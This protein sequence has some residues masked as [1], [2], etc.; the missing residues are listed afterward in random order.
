MLQRD[1]LL[2]FR[3]DAPSAKMYEVLEA[4]GYEKDALKAMF[5]AV[6]TMGFVARTNSRGPK[7]ATF[8]ITSAGRGYLEDQFSIRLPHPDGVLELSK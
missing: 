7:A 3:V 6:K 8:C 1:M 2:F 4:K 5:L